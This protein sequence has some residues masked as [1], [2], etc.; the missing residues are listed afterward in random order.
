VFHF[1]KVLF[2]DP[3]QAQFLF[4]FRNLIVFRKG[5]QRQQRQFGFNVF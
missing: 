2:G 4:L 3:P 5:Q 1:L